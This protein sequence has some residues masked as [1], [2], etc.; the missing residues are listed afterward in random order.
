M[1]LTTM[2][3]TN[4]LHCDVSAALLHIAQMRRAVCQRLLRFLFNTAVT[5]K[6]H[7]E[8]FPS[9]NGELREEHQTWR[10]QCSCE[11]YAQCLSPLRGNGRIAEKAENI[12]V[13][14]HGTICN[15]LHSVYAIADI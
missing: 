13:A 6:R 14:T 4:V 11:R 1:A 3:L 5:R 9:L 15:W 12:L 7:G 2:L 10:C 8:S